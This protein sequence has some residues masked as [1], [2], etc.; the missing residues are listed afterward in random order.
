MN[1]HIIQMLGGIFR[2]IPHF[3]G[4]GRLVTAA[5]E[6]LIGSLRDNAITSAP[7]VLGTKVVVDLRSRTEYRVFYDRIYD[8]DMLASVMDLIDPEQTFLDVGANVGFYSVAIAATIR[9]EG[10]T[11]KV[12]AFEPHPMNAARIRQNVSLNDLEPYC[13]VFSYGLSEENK[14]SQ[15]VL[16]ED[17]EAGSQTGNASLLTGTPSDSRFKSIPVEVRRLDEVLSTAEAAR[18]RVGFLKVDIEGHEQQ[19][20]RGA[21][22]LITKCR[23]TV[24]LE[25]NKPLLP[26]NLVAATSKIEELYRMPTDYLSFRLHRGSWLRTEDLSKFD[27]IDNVLMVPA[28]RLGSPPYSHPQFSHDH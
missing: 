2:T 11:G 22:E 21:H 3:K 9:K 6:A 5:N 27:D 19:L 10:G 13:E 16:R 18:R 23:P 8:R 25:I 12:L 7:F 20:L 4:R 14:I 1:M 24:L 15:L 26:A 17:F 28:E